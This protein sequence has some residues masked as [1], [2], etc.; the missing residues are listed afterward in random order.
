M[1][2]KEA[3]KVYSTFFII[4]GVFLIIGMFSS[5]DSALNFFSII[6]F[7]LFA[8]GALICAIYYRCAK[9]NRSLYTR[10]RNPSFCPH[11]GNEIE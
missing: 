11:C 3:G 9:C 2:P 7:V 6:G 4:G 1:N 8:I 5:N 10:G